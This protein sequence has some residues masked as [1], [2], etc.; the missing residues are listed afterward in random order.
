MSKKLREAILAHSHLVWRMIQDAWQC[1]YCD[2]IGGFTTIQHEKWC[3]YVIA[4][5]ESIKEKKKNA[6]TIR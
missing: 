5:D 4:L 6:T 1:R 3:P 2:K